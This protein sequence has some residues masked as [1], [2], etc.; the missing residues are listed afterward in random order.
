MDGTGAIPAASSSKLMAM[1]SV[2]AKELIRIPATHAL[3]VF[4]DGQFLLSVRYTGLGQLLHFA[5]RSSFPYN[6]SSIPF[7]HIKSR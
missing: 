5:L 2:V 3:L 4:A 7:P 6:F 1:W